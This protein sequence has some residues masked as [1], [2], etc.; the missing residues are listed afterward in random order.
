[1]NIKS[2]V[3]IDMDDTI[4]NLLE[5]WVEELNKRYNKQYK[6]SDVIDWD[7]VKCFPDLTPD[8]ILS[9][10]DDLSIYDKVRPYKDAQKYIKL[11]ND[12]DDFEIYIA[13]R[14]H[15]HVFTYKMENLLF[16]YFPFFKN[17]QIICIANKQLLNCDVLI[18]DAVHNLVGGDYD[19]ILM[20][21]PYNKNC[22]SVDINDLD[23]NRDV[24]KRATNWKDIYNYLILKQQYHSYKKLNEEE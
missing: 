22:I 16:K 17:R 19:K 15:P 6:L 23:Y 1:M 8:Q 18:D 3:C 20:D 5:V 7:M 21:M 12:N 13:T 24:I 10:L 2:I 4:E 9:V 14:T 11:L